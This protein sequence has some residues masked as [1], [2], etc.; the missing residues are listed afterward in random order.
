MLLDCF[1]GTLESHVALSQQVALE[2][3]F[4]FATTNIFETRVSGR[5]VAD[6]CR[7]AAKVSLFFLH[8]T[9]LFVVFLLIYFDPNFCSQCHPAES[10]K[11][12][13]PHCCNAIN[14]IA[15]S[16][17]LQTNRHFFNTFLPLSLS[18]LIHTSFFTQMRKFWMKKN[19]TKS[20]CGI[21]NCCP[22][23]LRVASN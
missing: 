6:M 13:V 7:A 11:M 20:Y 8:Q 1:S 9:R 3:V 22:R 5:M 10:L 19:L 15:I 17:S 4:N 18:F 16:K 12:F 14:H 23:W 21:S 2:K